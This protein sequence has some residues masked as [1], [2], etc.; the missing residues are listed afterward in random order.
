MNA[1]ILDRL[2]YIMERNIFDLNGIN[3]DTTLRVCPNRLLDTSEEYV[4]Q[5]V[6]CPSCKEKLF[7]YMNFPEVSARTATSGS[8]KDTATV[9]YYVDVECKF[10][11]R[12]I[13]WR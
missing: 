6:Y 7:I 12:R 8:F 5:M 4:E 2:A 13:V 3:P 9:R 11:E 1:E 10:C